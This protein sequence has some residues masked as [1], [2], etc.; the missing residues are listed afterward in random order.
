MPLNFLYLGHIVQALPAAKIV[1]LRRNPMDTCLSNFRQL[2]A[3]SFSYYNYHYDL[4]DTGHYFRLFDRLMRKWIG[5]FGERIHVVDYE[6]LVQEPEAQVRSLLEYC[7]LDW[8]ENCLNFHQNRTAVATASAM[9][10]RQPLYSSS[11]A[12]WKKYQDQL[13]PLKTI[14]D[15]AGI[16]Y[17]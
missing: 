14:F 7:G 16:D 10:V 11:M 5:L 1:L 6:T 13:A 17:Q 9:Q 8:D 15:E 12:R 3:V 2:F 4:V